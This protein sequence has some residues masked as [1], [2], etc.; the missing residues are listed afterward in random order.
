MTTG[1]DFVT[2]GWWIRLLYA[3]FVV[4]LKWLGQMMTPLVS[5]TPKCSNSTCQLKAEAWWE[6]SARL[7][8]RE[9]FQHTNGN[10]L[11]F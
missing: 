11:Y 4:L 10:N 9:G 7:M 2:R 1:L 6:W 3:W 8:T 5:A